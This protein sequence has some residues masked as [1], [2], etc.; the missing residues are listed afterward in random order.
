MPSVISMPSR[1]GRHGE[2]GGDAQ[3]DTQVD[4]APVVRLLDAGPDVVDA[5]GGVAGPF[6]LLDE[7]AGVGVGRASTRARSVA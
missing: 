1:R 5:T 6:Q 3:P 4:Q 7:D 2:D